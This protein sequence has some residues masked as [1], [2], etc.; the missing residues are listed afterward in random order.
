MVL[1]LEGP[2]KSFN[3]SRDFIIYLKKK[4]IS[5]WV[6]VLK[7]L[8]CCTTHYSIPTYI[9]DGESNLKIRYGY[10]PIIWFIKFASPF[11]DLPRSNSRCHNYYCNDKSRNT[12]YRNDSNQECWEI[13]RT[14]KIIQ[15]ALIKRSL[16]YIRT[17]HTLCKPVLSNTFAIDY[18][19]PAHNR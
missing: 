1:Y 17:V 19:R 5:L 18:R 10:P 15:T 7:F 12:I 3:K 6:I 11:P 13:R 8:L 4:R 9:K 14:E 2:E 16:D